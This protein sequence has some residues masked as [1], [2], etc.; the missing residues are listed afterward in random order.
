VLLLVRPGKA[1]SRFRLTVEGRKRGPGGK[2]LKIVEGT[3]LFLDETE[4]S[5]EITAKKSPSSLGRLAAVRGGVRLTVLRSEK[6][7]HLKT[8]P[9]NILD[10]DLTVRLEGKKELTIRLASAK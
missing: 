5:V 10:H 3:P 1:R 7:A 4:G 2:I 6:F 8:L 9:P